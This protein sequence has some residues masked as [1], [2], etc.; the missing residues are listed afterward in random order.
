MTYIRNW[1]FRIGALHGLQKKDLTDLGR[2]AMLGH[3]LRQAAYSDIKDYLLSIADHNKCLEMHA[4]LFAAEAYEAMQ[5][6]MAAE[7]KVVKES[8]T[9]EK[10]EEKTAET[11]PA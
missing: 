5:L 11:T 10:T 9:E 1:F 3:N 8:D 6:K 7:A 2:S 4:P